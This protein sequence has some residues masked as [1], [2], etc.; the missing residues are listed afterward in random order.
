MSADAHRQIPQVGASTIHAI[1]SRRLGGAERFFAR[2]VRAL[3]DAGAPTLAVVRRGS[4]LA[5]TLPP[6]PVVETGMRNG[7]DVLTA[8]RIRRLIRNQRPQIVQTYLGRAS[9]LTRVP[10]RSET[11]HVARLGGYYRPNSYRHAD[12]WIGNTRG[13]CDYLVRTGFPADRVFHIGNFAEPMEAPATPEQRSTARA[14]LSVPADA[15]LIF[16][17]GRFVRK[18]GF[19]DLLRAFAL[20]PTEIDARPLHLVVAG[21]GIMRDELRALESRLDITGRVH[22]PG[23][24][25]DPAPAYNAADVFVC[26]SRDEPLG[27]VV[28]EAWAHGLPVIATRAA[29]PTELIDDGANGVLTDIGA[30]QAL[31]DSIHRVLNAD[32]GERNALGNAGLELV[33]TT[34]SETAIVASYLQVYDVLANKLG[35]RR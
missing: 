5:R 25:H 19:D 28:L 7:A 1:G 24:L 11:V 16:S 17:L 22:W 31:S 21:D 8:W 18:K 29:G 33:R 20:L 14:G 9:R 27:N 32:Q 4:E 6:V 13:I 34:Y 2:L 35:R 26:P 12:A 10:R 30:P 3:H 15:L 23:W